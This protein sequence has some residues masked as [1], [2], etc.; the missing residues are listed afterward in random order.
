MTIEF[1]KQKHKAINAAM[2]IDCINYK[3]SKQLILLKNESPGV[4]TSGLLG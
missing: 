1:V 2:N 3:I 4:E